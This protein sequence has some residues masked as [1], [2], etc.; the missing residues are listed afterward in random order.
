MQPPRC[1]IDHWKSQCYGSSWCDH[2][3]TFHAPARCLCHHHQNCIS[4][5]SGLHLHARSATV[6]SD[7]LPIPHKIVPV[8]CATMWFYLQ[9]KTFMT[10]EKSAFLKCTIAHFAKLVTLL[11]IVVRT[12]SNGYRVTRTVSALLYVLQIHA[13]YRSILWRVLGLRCPD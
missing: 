10:V 8:I 4:L 3:G 12:F 5:R 1:S 11:G 6:V 7:L 2:A 9:Q 13:T